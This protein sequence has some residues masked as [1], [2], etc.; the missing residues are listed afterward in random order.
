MLLFVA[1]DKDFTSIESD[2]LGKENTNFNAGSVYYPPTK[3]YNKKLD[4]LQI[5]GL[6]SNLF[7]VFNDP[8]Y[9]QTKAGIVTQVI[10]NITD[11]DFGDNPVI[12]SVILRIPYFSKVREDSPDS[13]GNTLYSIEDS[14]YGSDPIKLSIYQNNYFLRDFNPNSEFNNPQ[15]YYS[16]SENTGSSTDYYMRTENNAV[17]F[18]D[19]KG[20]LIYEDDT[21]VPSGDNIALSIINDANETETSEILPPSL[22]IHLDPDF[23]TSAIL[24]KEGGSELSNVNNFNNYFRGL[25]FKA[26]SIGS[27]GNMIFLNM[28][29]SDANLTIY[30][31]KDSVEDATIKT[32]DTYTLNFSGIRLNT[33]IND[34][35]LIT[36]ENGDNALGDEKLYLKGNSGSMAV[37]DLFG[38]EDLDN[39]NISDGLEDFRD[40]FINDD[41]TPI[42]LIN[43]AHLVIYEDE[44]MT[45]PSDTYHKYDRIYAYD[46]KN[47]T[48]LIDYLTDFSEDTGDPYN[49]KFVHL[50][51]RLSGDDGAP[52]YKIRITEHLNN[53]LLR[54]S[55]NTKLGLVLSTNVNYITT[56]DILK[57]ED[58]VTAVPAA[59]ILTPRGTILH[60]TNENVAEN[61][62]MKLEIFYTEP[63]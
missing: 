24:D 36:L 35:N 47:N 63:K 3:A 22:R 41:G 28:R 38:N 23:W 6:F 52:K 33:F 32:Q 37:I 4:S 11:P 46:V 9:G 55:T 25:Y 30:Y 56:A 54:D 19:Y 44:T 5:N 8:A 16:N 31:S 53:I 34:Y 40:A 60:G 17:N 2:V 49:S 21:F 26:E 1:C 62:R 20:A 43:E 10:P 13:E 61:R 18:D 59:A 39:N 29:S 58:D 57:S 15:N 50:G 51:Q 48:A 12:D 42:R 14:L 45:T 7:G 27:D